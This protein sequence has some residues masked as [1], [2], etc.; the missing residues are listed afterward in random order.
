MLA[1]RLWIGLVLVCAVFPMAVH[2][3]CKLQRRDFGIR[4]EKIQCK[5]ISPGTWQWKIEK[6]EVRE[7]IEVFNDIEFVAGETVLVSARGCVNTGKSWMRYVDPTGHHTDQEYHGLVW[8]P[9]ARVRHKDMTLATPVGTSLVRISSISPGYKEDPPEAEELVIVNPGTEN[10]LRLGYEDGVYDGDVYDDNGYSGELREHDKGCEQRDPATVTI[11]ITRNTPPENPARSLLAFDPIS[12]SDDPNGFMASPTWF[13]MANQ[14]PSRGGGVSGASD[15]EVWKTCNN[16]PYAHPWWPVDE[17]ADFDHCTQQASLDQPSKKLNHCL[18]APGLGELHGHV[19]WTPVTYTGKLRFA[20]FSAD[21]DVD[22][23]LLDFTDE[24]RAVRF[25]EPFRSRVSKEGRIDAILTQDSQN[26][27]S[28]KNALWLEFARY[29]STGH[30]ADSGG[31]NADG[32]QMF[33]YTENGSHQQ[34]LTHKIYAKTAVV[35]GLLGLD[36]VHECHTELHPVYA[37]AVR[38]RREGSQQILTDDSWMIFVRNSG[39]E[40]DCAVGQHYLDRESFTFFLPEPPGAMNP[41]PTVRGDSDSFY[42]NQPG[43]KWQQPQYDALAGGVY[44]TFSLRPPN[45]DSLATGTPVRVHGVLH[46]N[47]SGDDTL[48]ITPFVFER[49]PEADDA[50]APKPFGRDSYPAGE[51]DTYAVKLGDDHSMC[52]APSSD[53]QKADAIVQENAQ[54]LRNTREYAQ[55]VQDKGALGLGGIWVS[56]KEYVGRDIGFYS[57]TIS[58][59][60]AANPALDFGA[61]YEFFQ[62]PLGSVEFEGESGLPRGVTSSNGQH[63]NVHAWSGMGG[64]RVQLS[65]KLAPYVDLKAGQVFRT[66]SAGFLSTPDFQHFSGHDFFLYFGTGV[67][68]FRQRPHASL[69]ISV[70]AMVLPETGEWMLRITFGPHFRWQSPE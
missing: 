11:T 27:E 10:W 41:T 65:R 25:Q 19:D 15:L 42:S 40:G 51:F 63:L 37:I 18:L 52:S 58:Y 48:P 28:Y 60:G 23:Q 22:M 53:P 61:R 21:G 8:I 69:R 7:R 59:S 14:L 57:G 33:H 68:P 43:L 2:A 9:G 31:E 20:D 16:F 70:G 56:I 34:S 17:G 62:T 13:G 38:A 66:A 45:C 54:K 1:A 44:V 35:T 6:P 24:D 67:E 47:W 55:K 64:L 49:D 50:R 29:E 46:L 32:W 30:F 5:D 4:G 26:V 12:L 36:C 3:Q 39:D